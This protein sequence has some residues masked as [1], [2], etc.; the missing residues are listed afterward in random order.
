M[1]RA[2]AERAARSLRATVCRLTDPVGGGFVASLSRPGGNITGISNPDLSIVADRLKLLREIAP[3]LARV[4]VIF[5]PGYPTVPSSLRVIEAAAAPLGIHVIPAG[6]RELADIEKSMSAFARE[7][8][9]GV[10]VIQS[11][12]IITLRDRIIVLATRHGLPGV[13]PLRNFAISGGLLS[14]GNDQVASYRHAATYF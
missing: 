14:Y 6:V 4:I 3:R 5:E 10:L 8:N 12:P 2:G 11:P 9:G 1:M 13:Y 7:P